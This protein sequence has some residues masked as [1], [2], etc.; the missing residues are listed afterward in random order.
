MYENEMRLQLKRQAAAH[1]EHLADVLA[2]RD[3]QLEEQHNKKLAK[4]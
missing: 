4:R 2:L 3:Q 1:S